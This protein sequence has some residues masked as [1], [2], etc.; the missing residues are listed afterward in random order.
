MGGVGGGGGG[1]VRLGE[2]RGAG[3]NKAISSGKLGAE[4]AEGV[5]GVIFSN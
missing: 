1:G 5:G 4:G 2:I 3:V